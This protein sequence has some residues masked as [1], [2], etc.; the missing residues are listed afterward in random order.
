M[1]QLLKLYSVM[2]LASATRPIW[3]YKVESIRC[4]TLL[5]VLPNQ[6]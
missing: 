4:A 3:R 1:N 6:F 2:A 5:N